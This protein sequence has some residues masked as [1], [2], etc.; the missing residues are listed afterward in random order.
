V[1]SFSIQISVMFARQAVAL[2]ERVEVAVEVEVE[3]QAEA[4]EAA[5]EE[6][7][8]CRKLREQNEVTERGGLGA[9]RG[10]GLCCSGAGN[11]GRLLVAALVDFWSGE[12]G[13]QAWEGEVGG[14]SLG[15][16]CSQEQARSCSTGVEKCRPSV[17]VSQYPSVPHQNPRASIPSPRASLDSRK[18][19]S[20]GGIRDLSLVFRRRGQGT[21]QSDRPVAR[22]KRGVSCVV[23]RAE[24]RSAAQR[25][26][27]QRECL[28]EREFQGYSLLSVALLWQL[29][30]PRLRA[31]ACLPPCLCGSLLCFCIAA[32]TTSQRAS[33][34][35]QKP[36][37]NAS[38]GSVLPE[39][40]TISSNISLTFESR[41]RLNFVIAEAAGLLQT[42]GAAELCPIAELAE[43]D[44]LLP[45]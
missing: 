13:G 41:C 43:R 8:Q 25:S 16:G 15:L 18:R 28:G 38:R 44:P 45:Q 10:R 22:P 2:G 37:V 11:Q 1:L 42:L 12:A 4:E 9:H 35:E 27:E 30:R 6:N 26:A 29:F 34:Q 14:W 23:A 19:A 33:S 21:V 32:L 24:C 5:E 39:H 20:Q 3:A 31:P 36:P 17:P 40:S 7:D